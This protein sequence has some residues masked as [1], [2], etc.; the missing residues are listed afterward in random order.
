MYQHLQNSQ[1]WGP[2]THSFQKIQLGGLYTQL[3]HTRKSFLHLKWDLYL[4]STMF[5]STFSENRRFAN[6]G[7]MTCNF[8]GQYLKMRS[9]FGKTFPL[10]AVC[11][12][13]VCLP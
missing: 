8:R 5:G 6:F 3:A 1:L 9:V 7:D 11:H 2:C 12:P 4:F 13:L 10:N